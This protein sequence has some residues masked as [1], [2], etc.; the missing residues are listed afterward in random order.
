[1]G[2][3]PKGKPVGRQPGFSGEKLE[4]VCSFEN[5]WRTRDHGLVYSDITKQWFVRYGYDL[6]FEKNVP[7]KIDDWV[8]GNRREGLTGE[9]LE[10][11]KQFE[12]KKQKELRQKLGGFFRNRFSGR[13]LHHAAVK[14]VVKAMQGMTGNA[15]RPRRKSNLAFYSSKYYETRLKE[16]FDKKWNEAKASCPAK[17]RLAMCQEYVRKAWA[18]E[19][20]TF[21]S[22][23]IR[24]ADEEHQQAVDAYR[25]SR[26]L[27]EQSAESY[28]EALETLDE[29]AIPLA[30]ALSDRYLIRSS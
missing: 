7:G 2:R 16:G 21:T 11:E 25:R 6:D 26:T 30:D 13:K 3:K 27:P 15:A 9:A 8:P 18:A 22:Q 17:A 29:V 4:W 24:E 5:D 14:S 23:V 10:E 1:M 12:E 20:E 28:H 19:D